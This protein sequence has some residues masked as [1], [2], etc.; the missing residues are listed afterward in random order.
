[1]FD[2]ND[3]T[4]ANVLN[5]DYKK[6]RQFFSCANANGYATFFKRVA[7]GS[8]FTL[9]RFKSFVAS[10]EF[11]VGQYPESA[12]SVFV[13]ISSHGRHVEKKDSK[14]VRK[15][16]FPVV[17]FKDA[18]VSLEEIGKEIS[19]ISR[20]NSV[21]VMG[22]MCNTQGEAPFIKRN[23]AL[24]NPPIPE[25]DRPGGIRKET[26]IVSDY[27]EGCSSNWKISKL[28]RSRFKNFFF[29]GTLHQNRIVTFSSSEKGQPAYYNFDPSDES[30][31]GSLVALT[32]FDLLE[33]AIL[34]GQYEKK[35][36]MGNKYVFGE[37]NWTFELLQ[38]EV[39]NASSHLFGGHQRPFWTI[40]KLDKKGL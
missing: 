26:F 16:Q 8:D 1:M 13:F 34:N 2:T 9:E 37:I 5:S 7:T 21:I 30:N 36:S 19:K 32:F 28:N 25:Q 18:V 33:S 39:Q 4:T 27:N 24:R 29:G 10:I 6:A 17:L 12:H 15:S 40:K 11:D 35:Y 14:K 3:V 38:D 20:L 31:S 23:Q 22:N